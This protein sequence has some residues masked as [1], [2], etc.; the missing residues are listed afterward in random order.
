MRTDVS[1]PRKLQTLG[2]GRP[3]CIGVVAPFSTEEAI[4]AGPLLAAVEA[5]R[6]RVRPVRHRDRPR[7]RARS[8][9][10]AEAV[11][12]ILAEPGCLGVVGPKNSGCA[13]VA[14]PLA[15]AAGVPLVLP[16][17]TADELTG[18][19]R[20]RLPALRARPLDRCS[21]VE[22]AAELGVERLA[23]LADDTAYGQGLARTVAP[24]PMLRASRSPMRLDGS[25]AA[26]LAMGEVEQAVLMGELRTAAS[27]VSSSRRRVDRRPDRRPR[28][29]RRR[30]RLAALSRRPIDG[31]SVYAAEAA[32]AARILLATGLGGPEAIRAGTF[33]GETGR[34]R[35]TSDG[36]REGAVVSRYRV[37]R[38]RRPARSADPHPGVEQGVADVDDDVGDDDERRGE[39]HRAD[40]DRL[41]A[42]DHRLDGEA[43]DARQA[44]DLLGDHESAEHQRHVEA[45]LGE[46]RGDRAAQSVPVHHPPLRQPLARAVRM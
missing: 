27:P 35:F 5:G 9:R 11:A 2:R 32:D 20:R 8:L 45:E 37:R 40:D 41:V 21:A 36:E 24:Q 43:P 22:L 10:A 14:A 7:R 23:V 17:A 38:R 33:D 42:A 44:E 25:D 28:R 34:I 4:V 16:C 15:A 46:Q 29:R 6:R 18:E 31:R 1:T 3:L 26:F 13:L 12:A 39:Q 19:R 30:R